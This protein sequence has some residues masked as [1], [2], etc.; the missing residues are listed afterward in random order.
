MKIKEARQVFI[1][2]F[3]L[4]IITLYI[5]IKHL[6]LTQSVKSIYSSFI[7]PTPTL[8]IPRPTPEVQGIIETNQAVPTIDPNPFVN[9]SIHEKC[10]GG[11][12]YVRKS[13]CNTSLYCC[14]L[15]DGTSKLMT[16]NECDNYYTKNSGGVSSS[17]TNYNYQSV[18][19]FPP[20]T[21]YYPSLG[22]S[23]TYTYLSTQDCSYWREQANSGYNA[24][25]TKSPVPTVSQQAQDEYN[26]LLKEHKDACDAAAAE[27]RY[28]E[29]DFM[30][31][32]YINFSSSYDAAVEIEKR[33]QIY[34]QEL[35]D[36]GC[37]NRI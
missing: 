25:P 10:G 7:T 16:K 5:S 19:T 1:L 13:V 35:Y 14:F 11:T 6:G 12:R 4:F 18:P 9:C 22:Y 21:I 30:T 23:Q 27:W 31:N 28:L 37:I 20:C 33:R 2:F 8:F 17:K 15:N 29:E 24:V 26:Q 34:Q 3:F 36:A 32:E